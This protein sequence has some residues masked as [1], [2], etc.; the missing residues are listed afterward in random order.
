M[1]TDT[2]I[3]FAIGRLTCDPELKYAP[4]GTAVCNF[5][6]AVNKSY[7]QD[8]QKKEEVSFFNVVVWAKLAEVVKE[9]LSKGKRAAITGSLKQRRWEDQ[10]GN[11][12]SAVEI[13]ASSVQFLDYAEN[14]TNVHEGE[15]R[16]EGQE[17]DIPE[18]S[19]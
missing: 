19:R 12:R 15:P 5:S 6:I 14:K 4:S 16:N 7:T 3:V 9:Y 2:N 13:V 11:K 1:H 10:Q 8:G 18:N 17:E